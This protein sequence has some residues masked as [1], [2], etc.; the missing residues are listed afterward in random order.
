VDPPPT[1]VKQSGSLV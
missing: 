1:S